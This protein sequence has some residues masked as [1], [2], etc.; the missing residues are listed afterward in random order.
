MTMV[1]LAIEIGIDNVR[2][3]IRKG[4]E[5]NIVPLGLIGS[6]YLCPPIGLCM[7]DNYIFGEPAKLNAV[8]RPNETV[9][10][11]DYAEG[12][13]YKKVLTALITYVCNRVNEIF[14]E[15]VDDITFIVSPCHNNQSV[16]KYLNDC[17]TASGHSPTST[18]DSTLSFVKSNYN[19][20]L[21]DKLCVIDLRDCPAYAAIVSRS[22][23]SYST[24]GNIEL[25]DLS[26]KE[27]ENFIDEKITH[28]QLCDLET[29]DKVLLA[30]I[31]SE[32]GTSLS[33]YGLMDLLEG[34]DAIIPL[35][36]SGYNYELR[37]IVFQN[38]IESKIDKVWAQMQSLMQNIKTPVN[39]INQV[40]LFGT[41]F[42]SE[43]ICERFKKC[44]IGYGGN[45][46]FSILSK[47]NDDWNMCLSSLK[48]NFQSSGFAL[49]L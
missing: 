16:Q 31:Q 40:V 28:D 49:E 14:D 44:F 3:V 43:F 38:W 2:A 37:Q 13:I 19:V 21:G 12:K 17:I 24:L 30:W 45:P 25:T 34:K 18:L 33:R 47:P 7:G 11:S 10:I 5:F 8:S 20:A 36:F 27:C 26:I 22:A 46:K 42:Q 48:T 1:Q 35:S 23:Q 32:I 29:D 15:T 9:F 39:Q 4:S 41:L 6:S